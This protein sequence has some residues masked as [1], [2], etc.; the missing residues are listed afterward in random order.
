MIKRRRGKIVV[1]SGDG[2]SCPRPHFAAYAASKAALARFVETVAEEVRDQNVQ[3]NSLFPG[4]AYTNMTDEVL[5][6]GINAGTAEIERAERVRIN[7]GVSAEKQIQLALFL[8][9]ERSNHVS[10]KLIGV[11]D[12]WKKFESDNIRQDAY[13]LRRHMK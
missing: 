9:S 3:I 1:I 7:G 8:A 2:A 5:S 13:T 11:Q 4:D 6:A 12:D 10:G